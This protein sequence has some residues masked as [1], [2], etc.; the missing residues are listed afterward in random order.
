MSLRFLTLIT[1]H[2]GFVTDYMDIQRYP[3][4]SALAAA[5]GELFVE[6]AHEAIAE[7]GIFHTVLAGGSTP[8]AIHTWLKEHAYELNWA[9]V[10]LWFGDERCVPPNHPDSNY[11]MA[12]ETLLDALD[13]PSE[14]IHRMRGDFKPTEAADIYENDLRSAFPDE[15]PR[16]DLIFLGLG[17][18]GHTASLFPHTQALH[19][20]ERWVVANH[21][22]K[23]GAWRLTLTAPVLNHAR[24]I[25]FLVVGENK[26]N[27]L[28]TVLHG[29]YQP[30]DFPAQ[31]IHPTAGR[32]VWLVDEKAAAQLP[33]L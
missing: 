26:A 8:R 21:V 1:L 2:S 31:M 18:D 11:K 20:S 28:R 9:K 10:H 24:V 7:R 16:F 32:E 19:E 27:A 29:E 15:L 33:L 5:A 23:L 17:D 4:P 3:N 22:A 14:N 12:Q 13:I 6:L 30:D 25:A